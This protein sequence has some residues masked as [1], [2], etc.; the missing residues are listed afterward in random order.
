MLIDIRT[1]PDGSVIETD[2]CIV[3]AGPA[4]LAIAQELAG[5]AFRVCVL[6]TGG[7]EDEPQIQ[8]LATSE[9]RPLGEPDYPNGFSVRQRRF[10]GTANRW[11]IEMRGVA[12]GCRY[13]PLEP[14]DFE[15]RD[16][17]PYSGWPFGYQD[18]EPFYER[19]HHLC[20]LGPYTYRVEDWETQQDRQ[21][22]FPKHQFETRM[23]QV[24]SKSVFLEDCRH[25]LEQAAN[26]TVYLYAT[27][28]ELETNETATK[29]ERVHVAS[30]S[31]QRWAIAP[32]Q[33]ILAMGGIENA[34][35]LLLSNKTQTA[36]LGN[37]YDLVGRY[38]MDHPIV[39]SGTLRIQNPKVFQQ[40][41]LYDLRPIPQS[42]AYVMGK[43]LLSET[44]MRQE[45]I[46]SM[47]TA[48]FPAPAIY[49]WNL[50]RFLLPAGRHYKSAAVDGAIALKAALRRK[51]FSKDTLLL[52]KDVLGGLDDI[53]Y[54]L[55]R[56]P[57]PLKQL[58]PEKY[59]FD[60]G[61]WSAME[62]PEK[63]F[64]LFEV[65]HL[66]EQAPD[67]ENR[68]TLG[69]ERDRLGCLKA[70]LTWRWNELDRASIIRTQKLLVDEFAGAG[71]GTFQP[72]TD[73]GDPQPIRLSAHHTIG[74]TRMHVD[75]KQGVVDANCK[76]HGVS[77]VFIAG[78]SVFP[79]GGY[80]NPTLT[81]I[82]LSIRLADEIKRQYGSLV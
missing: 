31:G 35:L 7:L 57:N 28:T 59:G 4:G 38:L 58:L 50:L 13:V 21:I 23:F 17:V 46:L 41:A 62:H 53:L 51:A 70:Y 66:T 15:Q 12:Q 36:G 33:V 30:L 80:A 74:T 19:A 63:K 52:L 69:K 24:S 44:T 43:L 29:V 61:G 37:A 2:V 11:G 14:I 75:P 40:L 10:G 64:G 26:V 67:P 6:E 20:Q 49:R 3:G 27:A 55:S 82:A 5:Q 8:A 47:N 73:K 77:N 72:E 32:K 56:K 1:I 76:V 16:W 71:I 78:S 9:E 48:L 25:Q 79:T 42:D 22:P 65:V 60:T 54:F 81:I 45:R 39:R 18:L 34:R 68:V